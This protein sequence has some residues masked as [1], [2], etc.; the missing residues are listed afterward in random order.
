MALGVIHPDVLLASLTA[1]QWSEWLQYADIEPFGEL[2]ADFRAGQIAATI[3]NYAGKSRNAGASTLEPFD[4]M[5][6]LKEY[7]P[8]PVIAADG[9]VLLK[10]TAAQTRLLKQALFKVKE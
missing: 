9:G 5:P 2:R 6:A 8:E 1:S 4:F 7:A 3:A 10:D